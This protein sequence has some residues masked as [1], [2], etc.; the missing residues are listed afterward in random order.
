MDQMKGIP[1]YLYWVACG[2]YGFLLPVHWQW[3]KKAAAILLVVPVY[4]ILKALI[5]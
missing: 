3:W 5:Q 2:F 4:Y 1:L